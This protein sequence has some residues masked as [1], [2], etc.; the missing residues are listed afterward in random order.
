MAA[1]PC[2]WG[3]AIPL[4]LWPCVGG[5]PRPGP[6]L[7]WKPAWVRGPIPMMLL[8]WGWGAVTQ[9]RRSGTLLSNSMLDMGRKLALSV[10]MGSRAWICVYVYA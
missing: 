5:D 1:L 9:G 7:P 6:M 8:V 2:Y 3:L 10:Q 4:A